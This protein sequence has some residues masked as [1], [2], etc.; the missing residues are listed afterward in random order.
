M[1]NEVTL[2]RQEQK[3]LKVLN[4]V[5]VGRITGQQAAILLGLSLRQERRLA[6]SYR[7]RGAAALAHGNRGRPSTRRVPKAVQVK[8]VSLAGGEF[9]DFNDQHFTEILAE[10]YGIRLS[11]SSVRRIRRGAGLA[12]PRKRRAGRRHQ[13][14][15]RYPQEGMLLQVDGSKHDWLE[16]RGPQLVLLAAIDD[17]TSKLVYAC[18]REQEDAAGYFLMVREISRTR[19]L[20]LALYADRHTIFQSPKEP[21]LTEQL[22]GNPARSQFGRLVSDLSIQLIA[23]HS[24]QAKGRVERLFGTLQDRLVKALRRANART[25]AEANRVLETFLPA[26][27]ARFQQPPAHLGL[28]YLPWPPRT[29]PEEVFCFKFERVVAEDNTVSFC[30][31]HLAIPLSPRQRGYAGTRV[32]LRHDMDGCLAITYQGKT[33]A[34]HEPLERG[35]PQVEKFTPAVKISLPAKQLTIK[36]SAVVPSRAPKPANPVSRRPPT[37]PALDHPWRQSYKPMRVPKGP[38]R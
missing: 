31:H 24:P 13:R 28:A 14:R 11:R 17:A 26:F 35:T 16:G 10:E 38:L 36:P 6:A 20:P 23:A 1:D 25:L 37:M 8:V 7:R 22:A 29:R 5:Q 33:L 18:F 4:Q 32:E 9:R 19:G 2:T 21:S 34:V 27:N 3:R 30:G 12:S 15:E